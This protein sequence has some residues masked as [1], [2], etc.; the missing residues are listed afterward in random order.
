MSR[1]V[2]C[3]LT[4]S[5]SDIAKLSTYSVLAETLSFLT[6]SRPLGLSIYLLFAYTGSKR[7]FLWLLLLF[8]F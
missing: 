1:H 5:L 2:S 7:L 4:V 3:V 8:V 6:E